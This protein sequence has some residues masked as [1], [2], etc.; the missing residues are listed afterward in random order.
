[1]MTIDDAIKHCNEIACKHDECA[2]EHKQLAKWLNELKELRLQSHWKPSDEQMKGIECTIK[3]LKYQLNVGD[4]RLDS[5]YND[6]KKL[7]EE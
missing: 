7:R 3:T 4:N 5:L 6:L 2:S 1:M